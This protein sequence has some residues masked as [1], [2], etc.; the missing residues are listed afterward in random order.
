MRG[1]SAL[2]GLLAAHPEADVRMMVIWLPVLESDQ[3]PPADGVRK[4]LQDPRVSEYWDPGWWAS[5]KI[6]ERAALMV[7]AQG[8]E[9]DFGPAAIAWDLILLYPPGG[10]W[11]DPFP[12]PKWWSG[13]VVDVLEPVEKILAEARPVE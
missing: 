1:A 5:P 8:E 11:E 4:P 12:E 10:V 9:P 13:P 3:G 6:L 2:G 7:R